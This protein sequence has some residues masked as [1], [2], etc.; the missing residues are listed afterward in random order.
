MPSQIHKIFSDT[1]IYTIG[2]VFNRLLP[3]L[4][5]PIYTLYFPPVEYGIFSLVYSFWFFVSV[6]YLYGMETAFQKYFLEAHDQSTKS[7]IYSSTLLLIFISSV[8]FSLIIY[9]LADYISIKITG[10]VQ[11]AYLIKLLAFIL[12][13]DSLYRFPMILINSIQRSKLY[14]FVNSLAVILNVAVNI[15]LIIFYKMGIEAIFYSYLVSYTFLFIIS[16]FSTIKYF[17]FKIDFSALSILLKNAHLFLYYGIFMISIDLIDR[18]ILEYFKGSAEVGIYS[19]S[20]R[21]GIVMNLVITGF[22]VA[23]TPFFMNLKSDES[24]KE[25]FSKVFTYF[26]YGGL[27]VFLFFSLFAVDMVR[28][29]VGGYTLLNEKYW[30]GLVIVPYILIAYLFSGLYMNLNVASFFSNKIKYLIISSAAGCVSNIALNFILIPKFSI[31]GAAIA[32]MLSYMLMFVVLY[33]FSQKIYKINYEWGSI[34]KAATIT[35]ILFVINIYIPQ[36]FKLSYIYIVLIEFISVL[37]LFIVLLGSKSRELVMSY[38]VKK[39]LK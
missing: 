19:A 22:K 3:F 35:F 27:I 18:F 16:F 32:T 29:N 39:Q 24:N 6:F 28:L 34:F 17:V 25:I 31:T 33:Y 20:Y 11:N 15:V 12:V 13:A 38:I 14:S 8:L 1:I 10:N 23:W 37:I 7:K 30:S 26:C 4:L 2:S 21:I 5:L 36:F 9:L